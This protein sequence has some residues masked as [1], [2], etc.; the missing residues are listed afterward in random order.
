MALKQDDIDPKTI[1]RIILTHVHADHT[2]SADEV[3]WRLNVPVMA[4]RKDA[5][6]FEGG[7][8][9]RIPMQFTEGRKH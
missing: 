5:R 8:A 2:G 7:F 6:M 9:T 3:S 4:Y 1:K